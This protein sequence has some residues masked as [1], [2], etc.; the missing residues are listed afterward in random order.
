[1]KY[2]QEVFY[3]CGEQSFDAPTKCSLFNISL[4]ML[5]YWFA[6]TFFGGTFGSL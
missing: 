5:E 6:D 3:Y 4:S 1:M 2:Y